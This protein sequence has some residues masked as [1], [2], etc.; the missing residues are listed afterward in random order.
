MHGAANA[1]RSSRV[2]GVS[3]G[4]AATSA[5]CYCRVSSSKQKDD[6]Q[7]IFS[8]SST[9][10]LVECTDLESTVKK[11]KKIKI[12]LNS[13]QKNLIKRG[14]GASRYVY[15]ETV[16]Y[17]QQSGTKANWKAIKTELIKS[18][19]EWAKEIPYQINMAREKSLG[20]TK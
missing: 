11:S 20:S 19:P 15:N 5:I 4:N 16:K 10:S 9:S 17:L 8:A 12:S 18:L 13:T 3:P 1:S 2:P 6:L 7:P 14:M